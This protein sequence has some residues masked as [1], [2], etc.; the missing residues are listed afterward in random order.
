[1]TDLGLVVV[2]L[3]AVLEHLGELVLPVVRDDLHVVPRV[4]S[5]PP[6]PAASAVPPAAAAP[7][8]LVAGAVDSDDLT[9]PAEKD[10]FSH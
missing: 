7:I 5:A 4:S 9:P 2:A 6:A 8:P 1:M 3:A 10:S